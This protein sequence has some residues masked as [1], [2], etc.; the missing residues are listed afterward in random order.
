M[1]VGVILQQPIVN[2]GMPLEAL[3]YLASLDFLKIRRE[4][5]YSELPTPWEVANRYEVCDSNDRVFMKVTEGSEPCD[6]LC[7][8]PVQRGL[9]LRVTDMSGQEIAR[10]KKDF[11]CCAGWGC[12]ANFDCCALEMFMESPVGRHLSSSRQ[13]CSC[14]C[15]RF[16]VFDAYGKQMYDM[17]GPCCPCQVPGCTEDLEFPLSNPEGS[18]SG[19][20]VTKIWDGM[21]RVCCT[22]TNTFGCH[23]PPRM[24]VKRKLSIFG[25]LFALDYVEFENNGNGEFGDGGESYPIYPSESYQADTGWA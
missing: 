11:K 9:V 3:N 12:C 10:L 5:D 7:F 8:K 24:D 22:K 19:A 20:K 15:P 4:L 23:F 18:Y 16:R 14:C 2:T 13:M 25:S 6:R 17:N 21:G 1:N